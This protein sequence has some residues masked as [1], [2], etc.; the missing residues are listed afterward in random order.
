MKEHHDPRPDRPY[1]QWLAAA[2]ALFCVAASFL[3]HLAHSTDDS[4]ITYR[5]AQN[6]A[7]GHGL[8]FNPGERHLA[9]TAPGWAVLLGL[10]ATAFGIGS[11]PVS[12]GFLSLLA[13]IGCALLLCRRWA[14]AYPAALPVLLCLIAANR[15]L[16]EVVGHETFAQAFLVLSA[17]SAL[18]RDRQV[19]AGALLALATAVRPDSGLLGAVAGLHHWAQRR[20]FPFR[21]LVSYAVPTVLLAATLYAL[22][23]T[24]IPASIAVKQAEASDPLFLQ[25]SG[26]LSGLVGWFARDFGTGA[27]AFAPLSLWGLPMLIAIHRQAGLR[28]LL[29]V[30][31]AACLYPLLRVNFAPWYFVFPMIVLLFLASLPLAAAVRDGA[32]TRAAIVSLTLL[33]SSWTSATWLLRMSGEPPDP[34]MR[35]NR[36]VA[37][38]IRDHSKPQDSVAAVEIGFL[39]F[40]S[41]RP[42]LDLIGLGSP[43]ALDALLS[44]GTA[45]LFFSRSP[46]FFVRHPVFDY[47]QGPI[48]K[49]ARFGE[50]YSLVA[51]LTYRRGA[52]PIEIYSTLRTA[53]VAQLV[54]LVD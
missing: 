49:D 4:F 52:A 40:Y 53:E 3:P 48:L 14:P 9:T 29:L 35:P 20:S 6:L 17:L 5:C 47:V 50:G 25:G 11:I 27:L 7:Q 21:L 44:G 26:Y 54:A 33:V 10:G 42:L 18:E 37:E 41:N 46:A 31:V 8:V 19:A 45:G 32:L 1:A 23:G 2:F 34:R 13:L 16:V 15:W 38:W 24:L 39:S 43:G 22:C 51:N 30:A 28:L 12:S 36:A